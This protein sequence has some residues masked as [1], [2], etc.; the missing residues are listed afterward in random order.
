M[1]ILSFVTNIICVAILVYTYC[2]LYYKVKRDIPITSKMIFCSLLMAIA[3][4]TLFIVG[5]S[6]FLM[7]IGISRGYIW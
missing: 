4:V 1:E 3:L 5:V 2:Y 6:P 7:S